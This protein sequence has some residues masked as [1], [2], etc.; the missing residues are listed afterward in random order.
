MFP[1]VSQT[2]QLVPFSLTIWRREGP[3]EGEGKISGIYGGVCVCRGGLEGD[4]VVLFT[5]WKHET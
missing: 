5:I 1:L 3:D 2:I 4:A